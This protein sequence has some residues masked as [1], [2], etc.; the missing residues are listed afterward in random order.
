M[1]KPFEQLLD[2][3][4]TNAALSTNRRILLEIEET[5]QS[6]L[7]NKLS[8]DIQNLKKKYYKKYNK[9]EDTITATKKVIDKKF[10]DKK[11]LENKI[12]LRTIVDHYLTDHSVSYFYDQ[13]DKEDVITTID[14]TLF[15]ITVLVEKNNKKVNCYDLRYFIGYKY[16]YLYEYFD[17]STLD[18]TNIF[19]KSFRTKEQA[20]EYGEK[21]FRKITYE[22]YNREADLLASIKD[23]K[24]DVLEEFD[25][26]GV[27][28]CN[29]NKDFTDI[30]K[31]TVVFNINR[32][33]KTANI[34]YIG[35]GN[36][37][38]D[39]DDE[40]IIKEFTGA[41]DYGVICRIPESL[42]NVVKQC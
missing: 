34:K 5:K 2:I 38:T 36:F 1:L 33:E 20:I 6:K 3:Q 18:S 11:P 16:Y 21:H 9:I 23:F 19:K 12:K 15:T 41:I 37:I 31:D 22:V 35:H 8:L 39:N 7:N 40:E 32:G 13:W 4:Q 10:I 24:Y 27:K 17:G 25:F 14:S 30:T 26:R 28:L 42:I 29:S